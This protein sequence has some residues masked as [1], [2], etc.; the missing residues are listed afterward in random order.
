MLLHA[1]RRWPQAISAHHWPYALRHANLC[2]NATPNL[3]HE[4]RRTPEQLFT[5]TPVS[6]NRKYWKPF[7]FPVYVL[8][9]NLQSG[10]AHHKW[11]SRARVGIYLDQSPIHN[12]NV[13]LVLHPHTGHM[14]PQFH[15]KFDKAFDILKEGQ[16][17]ATWQVKTHFANSPSTRRQSAL[18][19]LRE[20]QTPL[21]K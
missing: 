14:S 9:D 13:A 16:L 3:Q 5:S 21:L 1:N 12:L 15:V 19:L 20:L 7:G 17:E 6:T 18:Q 11:K 10:N 8:D 4:L 2:I